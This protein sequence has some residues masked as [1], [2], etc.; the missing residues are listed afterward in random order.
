MKSKIVAA[1]LAFFLGG[2]GA[3]KFYIG[4]IGQGILF[5]LLSWTGIPAIIA[6]I[7]FILYLVVSEE[8]F[9]RKYCGIVVN[10]PAAPTSTD[11][12]NN[13]SNIL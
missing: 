9:N 12:N 6:F 2:F 1:L 10:T 8:E 5:L 7:D 13:N 3:H 11:N 4:K